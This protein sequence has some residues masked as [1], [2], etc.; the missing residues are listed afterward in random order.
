M[1]I[2]VNHCSK[3]S[4]RKLILQHIELLDKIDTSEFALKEEAK[5]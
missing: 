3:E 2:I 5:G 4:L 1:K